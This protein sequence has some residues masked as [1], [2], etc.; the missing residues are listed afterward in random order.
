MKEILTGDDDELPSKRLAQLN[1]RRFKKE[2]EML[3]ALKRAKLRRQLKR[4]KLAL[5]HQ[6][7]QIN[8]KLA[9]LDELDRKAKE[10][11]EARKA[12]KAK[13]KKNQQNQNNQGP[14]GS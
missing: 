3:V 6:V 8:K 9:V 4:E 14:E 7:V 2:V 12:K 1:I 5:L 13:M 10:A 11:K